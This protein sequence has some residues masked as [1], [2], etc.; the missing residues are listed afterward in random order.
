M[1][2]K[3]TVDTEDPRTGDHVP[4]IGHERKFKMDRS[5]YIGNPPSC[6]GRDQRQA[7]NLSARH[8]GLKPGCLYPPGSRP[9][10]ALEEHIIVR[11]RERQLPVTFRARPITDRERQC[12]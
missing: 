8:I 11:D 1:Q 10:T 9:A 4:A 12:V 3:M 6:A 7:N 2:G 5:P